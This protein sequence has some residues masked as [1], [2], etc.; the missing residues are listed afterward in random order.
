M[1]Y[2]TG[3]VPREIGNLLRGY[4]LRRLVYMRERVSR[5]IAGPTRSL[6]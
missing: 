2:Q 3:N 5:R 6:R 1:C 4:W